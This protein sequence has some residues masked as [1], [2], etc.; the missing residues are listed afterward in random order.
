MRAQL[1]VSLVIFAAL[2]GG[3][4]YVVLGPG[5]EHAGQ[6]IPSY[7][8]EPLTGLPT[9]TKSGLQY[10]DLKVGQG[11]TPQG[12]T[13]TA[14]VHYTGWLLNG[15]KFDSSYDIGNDPVPFRLDRGIEG[16]NEGLSTMRVGGKRKL[17]IPHYLAYGEQG[18]QPSIP[19]RATLV[20]DVELV[21][22]IEPGHSPGAQ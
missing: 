10:F 16:W 12:S 4:V 21:N 7:P 15:T 5:L 19:P 3:V 8:G 2:V 17:I 18:A 14:M 11:A 1:I 20:F 9:R 22:V 13:S 6:T